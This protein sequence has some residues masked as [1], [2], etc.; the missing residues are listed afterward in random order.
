MHT[1]RSIPTSADWLMQSNSKLDSSDGSTKVGCTNTIYT[2]SNTTH[3]E[4]ILTNELHTHHDTMFQ[5]LNA[6][7]VVS[8]GKVVLIA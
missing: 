7:I 1:V 3:F 5:I 8:I 6:S 4:A 2:L